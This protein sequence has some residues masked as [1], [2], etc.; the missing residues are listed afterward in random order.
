MALKAITEPVAAAEIRW[1]ALPAGR[2]RA[3]DQDAVDLS[4][5][6]ESRSLL[7]FRFE[8]R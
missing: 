8:G 4:R 2:G 1:G 5:A 3:K 7:D 6:V